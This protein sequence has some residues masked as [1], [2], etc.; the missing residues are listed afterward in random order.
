MT[1]KKITTQGFD[2]FGLPIVDPNNGPPMPKVKPPKKSILPKPDPNV[3]C[4][5]IIAKRTRSK[6]PTI[7]SLTDEKDKLKLE[8][9]SLEYDL[10]IYKQKYARLQDSYFAIKDWYNNKPL[11]Q[12]IKDVFC[13]E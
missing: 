10:D 7:S 11:W 9:E 3:D 8:V 1:R 6:G 4:R 5:K 12:R 2:S 13:Y